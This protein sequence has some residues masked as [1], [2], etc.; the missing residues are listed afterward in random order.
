MDLSFEWDE[1]KAALNL[2]KHRISFE[3]ARTVFG[4]PVAVIFDDEE[5]SQDETRE[6][7]VGH[8]D[9]NRLLLVS[10]TERSPN[11]RI[12]SARRATKSE[13]ENY[14]KSQFH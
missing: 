1:S 11:I 10:F 6:I 9:R 3:E 13:R 12:I 14:E 7:I 8:S 4:D 5:H 2:K